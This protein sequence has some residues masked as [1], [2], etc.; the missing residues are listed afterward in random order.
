MARR[1][2]KHIEIEL[3]QR[4][5]DYNAELGEIYWKTVGRPGVRVGSRV[6]CVRSCG[7]RRFEIEGEMFPE[8]A[9]IYLLEHGR[10]PDK[11]VFH[12]N[13]DKLDNRIANL[14]N[15]NA[16]VG[17]MRAKARDAIVEGMIE[18]IEMHEAPPLPAAP[19]AWLMCP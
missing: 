16:E 6:G 3:A 7:H 4:I 12:V 18:P 10:W 13:K 19:L 8:A 1:Y 2:T 11:G 15:G 14:A 9:I 17:W 5:F